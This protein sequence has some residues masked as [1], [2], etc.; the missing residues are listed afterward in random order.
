MKKEKCEQMKENI[1]IIKSSD[2]KH[3][4]NENSK[5]NRKCNENL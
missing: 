5:H 4:L 1:R 2:E 3:N